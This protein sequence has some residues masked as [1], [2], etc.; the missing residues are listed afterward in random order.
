MLLWGPILV[1]RDRR[2]AAVMCRAL[3]LSKQ[4][5]VHMHA[6]AP[7][8]VFHAVQNANEMSQGEFLARSPICF[9]YV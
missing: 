3:V 4:V 7:P 9:A 6:I 8:Q 5:I 2:E 1:F